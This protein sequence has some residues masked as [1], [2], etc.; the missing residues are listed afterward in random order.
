ME[1]DPGLTDSVLSK[2][3]WGDSDED[4]YQLDS[5]SVESVTDDEVRLNR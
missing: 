5:N 3:G 2:L 1:P 4:A